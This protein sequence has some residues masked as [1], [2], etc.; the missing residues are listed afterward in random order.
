M[1]VFLPGSSRVEA[2]GPLPFGFAP[3]TPGSLSGLKSKAI[4]IAIRIII[5]NAIHITRKSGLKYRLQRID[6]LAPRYCGTGQENVG[7]DP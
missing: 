1:I 2:P 3:V 5:W 4:R 6:G 7:R